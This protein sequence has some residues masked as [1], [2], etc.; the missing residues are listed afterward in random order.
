MDIKNKPHYRLFIAALSALIIQAGSL[1][2]A[3]LELRVGVYNFAPLI[4]E[5]PDDRPHGLFIDVLEAVAARENWKLNYV[6]G[7]WDE[8]YSGLVSDKVDLLPCIGY[9]EERDRI[10]DFS[11]EYLFVDWG[12][13]YKKRGSDMNSIQD[14][15]GKRVGVLETS[16]FTEE[17]QRLLERSGVR[18][19]LAPKTEYAE[20]FA[21]VE[22][23]EVDAGINAQ[24]AGLRIESEYDLERTSIIFS[25]IKIVYAVNG[26]RLADVLKKLDYHITLMKADKASL[27]YRSLDRVMGFFP[28]KEIL[29]IWVS[30]LLAAGCLGLAVFLFYGLIL[31]K[32][33]TVSSSRLKERERDLVRWEH[34]FEHA[35]WGVAVSNNDGDGLALINPAYA[36][37]HGYSRE[38]LTGRPILMVYPPENQEH[39]LEQRRLSD[40]KGRRSFESVHVRKDGSRFPALVSLTTV[41]EGDAF[42]YRIAHIRDITEIKEAEARLGASLREK[43]ILLKEIHHRVKNN[44]QLVSAL[45]SL[46]ANYVDDDRLK[47]A[48]QESRNRIAAMT[49]VHEALYQSTSF[50]EIDFKKYLEQLASA[51]KTAYMNSRVTIK[52]NVGSNGFKVGIDFAIP[53]GIALN[54][55]ITNSLKHGFPD[56]REGNVVIDLT[57]D[58]SGGFEISAA[59]DGVGLP[60]DLDWRNSTSL[61]LHLVVILVEKQLE[62]V[63]EARV[64]GGAKFVMRFDKTGRSEEG[65]RSS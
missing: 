58:S 44:M 43:E 36:A 1:W 37:M 32:R 18:V 53:C 33:I 8:C 65:G 59:D 7:S 5:G 4:Y 34:V 50:A 26:G 6:A 28:K 42:L 2:A 63:L 62:G 52:I 19:E 48:F 38:E 64:D 57:T 27:Y 31:K 24:L 21:A 22:S 40:E 45:L 56:N 25:P 60:P 23:G 16:I 15:A 12:V 49:L 39:F 20:I 51:L 54:E 10:L 14:L 46:Q 17:F 29:P 13:V 3:P 11:R 61:G 30:R 35:D 41:E 9:S 47:E 55:L